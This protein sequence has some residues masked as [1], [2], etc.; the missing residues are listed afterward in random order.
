GQVGSN[1]FAG[2]LVFSGLLG[3]P[4]EKVTA[5]FVFSHPWA[6]LLMTVTGM[7]CLSVLGLS[8]SSAMKVQAESMV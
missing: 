7:A 4:A 3:L 8:I 5:M 2:L 6:A 1:E